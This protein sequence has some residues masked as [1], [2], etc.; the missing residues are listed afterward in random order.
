MPDLPV[1]G[2]VHLP[3]LPG[4][5]RGE[6]GLER[7]RERALRD[8][9]AL[10]AGG[11]DALMMENFGDAPFWPSSVPAYTVAQMSM[12]AA[13]LTARFDLPL[14]INV[15]RSDGVA[16]MAVAHASGARFVRVNVL[17]G[18]RVTDQGI[19]QGCA[20]E[21]LR[22]RKLLDATDVK[23]LADVDVKHSAP[24]AER[25]LEDEARD[26]AERGGADGLIVSGNATGAEPELDTAR[27]VRECT[28]L[29]LLIGSGVT[30]GNVETFAGIADALIVGTSLK[31]SIGSPIEIERVRALMSRL[32]R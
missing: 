22:A 27:R 12:I 28:N 16:A 31:P 15:L 5:P 4:S 30:P 18:A 32:G 10:A 3:P 19:V 24:L 9:E 2:M 25:P 11:V 17:T 7:V 8:A 20:H 1:I 23:I 21:L 6:L 14:G 13:A 26:A 29:P